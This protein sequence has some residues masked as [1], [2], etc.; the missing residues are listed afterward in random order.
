M[1]GRPGFSSPCYKSTFDTPFHCY[2]YEFPQL[3]LFYTVSFPPKRCVTIVKALPAIICRTSEAPQALP[4]LKPFLPEWATDTAA[5]L[6]QTPQGQTQQGPSRFE[7]LT[8]EELVTLIE[9]GKDQNGPLP[10]E[11]L[12]AI[13]SRM[14]HW[15]RVKDCHGKQILHLENTYLGSQEA[16][17]R[18]ARCLAVMRQRMAAVTRPQ[19]PSYQL[20]M[21]D[22]I[23]R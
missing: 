8:L 4:H 15:Q 22:S 10:N 19:L 23:N 1:E 21:C 6:S 3:A 16:R 13:R 18:G 2:G 5:S 11:A 7:T 12:V 14:E 9:Q 20:K 17:L